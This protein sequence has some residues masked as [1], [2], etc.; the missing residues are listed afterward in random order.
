MTS[1]DLSEQPQISRSRGKRKSYSLLILAAG[2]F[3]FGATAG[4]LYLVLR[5]VTLRIAVGPA[6]SDDQ[7][8]IQALAQTFARDRSPVRLSPITTEGAAEAIALFAT[9]K[10]DL[11]VARGD[12]NL[13]A[14]AE[15]VAILRKNV[16]VLWAPSGLPSK[17]SKK[18]QP[19]PKIKGIDDLAEHRVGVIGR[20]QANVTLLRVILAES[21][22]SPDKVAVAQFAANQFAEMARDPT[23]DAFM[24]VGPLDSKI[25]AEAIAATAAARGEPKFLPIEVSEAI[26]NKHP[27]YESEEIAG[28]TFSASPARPEDKVET[29]SVNHLII[30]PKSLSDTTV[31]TFVR[32]LFAV[33]QQLA[34]EV[35]SAGKIE[36]PDTDKDAALP[37]H[38]GAAAFIDGTERTFLERY[39]DYF[40]AAILVLSGLGSVGA[41]LRHSWKRN[42]REQYTLHRDDLLDL[43][44]KARQAETA[45]ELATMQGEADGILRE[46]LDCYDDGAIEEGD[47]SVIGLALEQFHHAVADRRVTVGVS[48]PDLLRRRAL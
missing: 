22:V 20:T 13:P 29:V 7:K 3:L 8:L 44:S 37:A 28:S 17:G 26:A 40:W 31:G 5:P 48:A 34:R 36:K 21:G 10:A 2:I 15:S 39:S 18:K 45:E 24:A 30:A 11:A 27:L 43:I 6:G 1:S 14:N 25:T 16:V 38:A 9:S 23:L 42:E 46:A 19:A 41:W 12:L 32:Q 4:A 47:L 33:R 35:P